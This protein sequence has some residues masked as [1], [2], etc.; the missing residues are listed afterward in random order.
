MIK[1]MKKQNSVLRLTERIY[2]SPQLITQ[3][4]FS[5]IKYYLD[6]R[7]EGLLIDGGNGGEDYPKDEPY[8]FYDINSKIGI[9]N[10]D[11]TLS[12]KPIHTMCGEVGT[13]YQ[14]LLEQATEMVD[15]GI[16]TIIMNV[17]SG[18]GQALNCFNAANEFRKMCDE[19]GVSVYGFNES[20]AASAAYA[21]LS[22]CDEVYAHPDAETGSVGVLV[23][24]LDE[25]KHMEQEGLKR[26]F[27]TAGNEKIPFAEDGSFKPEFLADLQYK[28]DTVYENFVSHVSQHMGLS[29][30]A[31]KATQ[32]KTFMSKDALALGLINGVKTEREFQDYVISKHKGMK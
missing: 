24:L 20:L 21:W 7:N 27:V 18:G 5:L 15:A 26:V 12:A 14:K 2:S 10:V 25:S 6:Q 28:V 19:N 16:K 3:E 9:L 30:E 1:F 23:C 4:S 11:G 13:S 32:A 22:V 17:S 8:P 29:S 31:I